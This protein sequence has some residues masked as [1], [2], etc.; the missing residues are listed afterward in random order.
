MVT[1]R[2]NV[3]TKIG[4]IETY[5]PVTFINK[6]L[7]NNN[8]QA[9]IK[10]I[11]VNLCS[12]NV[13]EGTYVKTIN[14]NG[15]DVKFLA[16]L[17]NNLE[18][19]SDYNSKKAGWF[20]LT[21]SEYNSFLFRNI[22]KEST[23][24]YEKSESENMVYITRANSIRISNQIKP[25]KFADLKGIIYER[26]I[27]IFNNREEK[28]LL[29]IQE[30]YEN[31]EKF[32]KEYYQ[33]VVNKDTFTLVW[34]GGHPAYH[35]DKNCEKLNKDYEN[36]KIPE[37]IIKKGKG[38]IIRFRQWFEQNKY[39]LEKP[40]T[41][42][43]KLHM[44]FDIITNP[45]AINIDNSGVILLENY[46]LEEIKSIIDDLL[47]QYKKYFYRDNKTKEILSKF[48]K[49]A[50]IYKKKLSIPNN[51]TK[52][53]DEEIYTL[54]KEFDVKFK[55]PL[56]KYLIEYYKVKLNPE[57]KFENYLLDQ[58]GFR[59]CRTCYNTD[60][61]KSLDIENIEPFP[62]INENEEDDLPF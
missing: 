47:E 21:D 52:F 58:I 55:S 28:W 38:E 18:Y 56:Y 62:D 13:F 61:P 41:F 34:E 44:A 29:A 17:D 4:E 36:F 59:Q 49:T 37:E 43:M 51:N 25:D 3:F 35:I 31:P 32:I 30:F 12:K 39:L 2:S 15:N 11:F 14:N 23:V 26:K 27:D 46:D 54:L 9:N 24:K 45:K 40:D 7:T 1:K 60:N 48:S 20:S 8:I 50:Y 6:P 5:Y 22:I 42:A 16:R 57:L 10:T 33:K 53:S 19:K